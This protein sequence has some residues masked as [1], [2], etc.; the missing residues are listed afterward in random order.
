MSNIE[1]IIRMRCCVER[2][3]DVSEEYNLREEPNVY[4]EIA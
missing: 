4:K 2:F 3:Y 1:K